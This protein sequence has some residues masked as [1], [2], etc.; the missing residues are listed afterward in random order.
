MYTAYYNLKEE[1]F[2][3]TPDPRFLHLAEPHREALS[4]LLEGVLMRRGLML[5][6]GP[7]GTGKTTIL[8]TALRI[9]SEKSQVRG[10]IRS[11][12]IVIPTLSRDEFLE[13]ILDEFEV[14][15]AGFS[16]PRRLQALHK[17]LL[18]T[19]RQNGV[20]VLLLDEAHLLSMDLLEEVRLLSNVDTYGGKLL[21]IILSGQPEIHPMLRRK[22]MAALQQ[23]IA[24][25]CTLRPLSL[26]E[27]R[28]YIAERLH[29]AGLRGPAPFTSPALEAVFGF[30]GGV[31][32]VINLVCDGALSLGAR[33][34]RK[35]VEPDMVE[36]VAVSLGL[37]GEGDSQ[38]DLALQ[39][40]EPVADD[41]PQPQALHSAVDVLIQAMK[42][43][44]RAA[45]E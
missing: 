26:V 19:Q 14:P 11:A 32:R 20:T 40:Q 12:F 2:R 43:A 8:H 45:Q 39:T 6:T 18:D 34:Q 1:A 36:E 42:R 4:V 23:R 16:K 37:N 7:V 13:A 38:N 29:A 44:R 10:Q 21:Q 35:H 24:S 5:F 41:I 22:E 27:T 25:R 31:P 28:A 9:L 15:S 33:T 30:S 17:M 3:L